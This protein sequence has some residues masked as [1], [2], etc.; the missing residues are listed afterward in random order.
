MHK[1]FSGKNL[2]VLAAVALSLSACKNG[3][4]F[5]KK[6]NSSSVTGWNYDDKNMGNYHVAKMKYPKAGPGLVFVQGGTFVMG[7][8]EED[9]MADWNNVPKRVTV[10]SF[11]IDKT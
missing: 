6:K 8:T 2:L 11:F 10:N 1:T 7:A 4:L 9:V 3:S 5:G